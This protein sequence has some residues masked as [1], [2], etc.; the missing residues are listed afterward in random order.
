MYSQACNILF[1]LI[2]PF[3]CSHVVL[4]LLLALLPLPFLPLLGAYLAWL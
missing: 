4:L 2:R 1:L 3:I